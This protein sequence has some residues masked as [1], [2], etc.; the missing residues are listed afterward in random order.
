MR[1]CDYC[2]KANEDT[3]QFCAG[4]GTTL[5]ASLEDRSE[6]SS[7]PISKSRPQ[8][9]NAGSATIILLAYLISSVLFELLL[10]T[11]PSNISVGLV[12][13]P[14]V[15]GFVMILVSSVLVPTHLKD[16]SCTGAAWVLG[17]WATIAT[18]LIIGLIIGVGDEILVMSVKHHAAYK[19]LKPIVQASLTPGFPQI[20]WVVA[21]VLIGPPI[22]EMM[23]RGVLYGGYCKSFGPMH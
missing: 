10:P 17:R 18:G 23:F 2:G 3:L 6:S 11:A 22:E 12:L 9:L 13:D 16:N 4:C 20:L 8:M 1:I 21:T 15:G 19:S 5:K 7:T 14:L